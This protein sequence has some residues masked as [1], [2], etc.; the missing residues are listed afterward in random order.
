[1][2]LNESR[3]TERA[4]LHGAPVCLQDIRKARQRIKGGSKKYEN[5]A[6]TRFE[7]MCPKFFGQKQFVQG[8]LF[9]VARRMLDGMCDLVFGA[10]AT[11]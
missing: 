9:A 7:H 3:L 5:L 1:M 4:E 10:N 2:G 6:K 8:F 11:D